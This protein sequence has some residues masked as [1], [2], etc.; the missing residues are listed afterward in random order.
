MS[1]RDF[2]PRP[3]QAVILEYESGKMG[4]SAVPGS[5]KTWTLSFLAA[6][7]VRETLLEMNQQI[8][9]VTL[10]NA[11][12]GKFDQQVREFLGE[13]SLGTLYRVRTLHGL[14]KD[15]VSERPGLVC[16]ADD[17]QIIDEFEASDMIREAVASWFAMNKE[18]GVEEYLAP[19]HQ[20][21][22]KSR[23]QWR[24]EATA[25]AADFIKR[26]KDFRRRPEDLRAVIKDYGR[27]LLL[28]EMCLHIYEAYERGLRY[29]GGVDF[30][31]LIRLAL[32]ALEADPDYLARLRWRWPFILEDEAQDSSKLQEEILR[33]LV[34]ENGNWVRVGD[35]NQAIY[36][37]FTTASPEFLRN[38]LKEP[39]VV[40]RQLPES[41]RSAPA[42]IALANRLIGWSLEHP[43]E[44]I[45]NRIPLEYPLIEPAGDNP[46]DEPSNVL[47]HVD[48]KMSPEE[49][50]TFVAQSLREWLPENS[51]RT[52]AVLLPTNPTGAEMSK[53][54]AKFQIPYIEVLKTTT[55]TRQVAG[56]LYRVAGY[57]ADPV[58]SQALSEA[59]VVWRRDMRDDPETREIATLLK[60][61]GRVEQFTAPRE[62][63]WLLDN[64]S[65][66]DL[67]ARFEIL[68]GFRKLVRRWQ[69]A[70]LLP[71]DQML[72]TIAGDIFHEAVDIATAYS[73]AVHMRG[74]FDVNP[75]HRL[76]D[77]VAELREIALNRR[78]LTGLSEEDEQF[79]PSRY[80]GQV[81][82]MT[83]HRA[84]GLEWDRVHLMSANNYDFPSA[85]P[86][87]TFIGEKFFARDELNLSAEALA[88][89]RAITQGEVYREG[90]A[91][92]EA[93]LEYA[94]ERL[95]L[96]YVGFT[97]AKRELIVTW[98]TGRDGRRIPAKPLP[99]LSSHNW[100]PET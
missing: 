19:D 23:F 49:E 37:T 91:T 71:V 54:L 16:L 20:N 30:Q 72:L 4:V 29:R 39:G 92:R 64:V 81:V 68:A 93:R 100:K 75:E 48:R 88:Q 82:V 76:R 14:A 35:P 84:K 79:D 50:R 56:S 9:V 38:F 52:V 13:D 8:L 95:R 61:A 33:K 22:E 7:L 12:R 51:D 94:A 55:S 17:F 25:I 80:K 41:G 43:N 53:V 57:L 85:D 58:E 96:L 98:N 28:A 42:I 27:P 5:G 62:S 89:L 26:A 2:T 10:V 69:E 40:P 87:D 31:D 73:I 47:L 70:T 6:K 15:I 44:E 63:D 32:D 67:P 24:N 11:A 99:F 90:L 34:G 59:F 77:C 83:L 66:D 3:S 18:F 86:F 74:M 1:S 45:R 21:S 60:R 36:E 46:P 78:N 65:R 97:R